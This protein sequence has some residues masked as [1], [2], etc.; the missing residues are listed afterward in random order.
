MFKKERKME[1]EKEICNV[2]KRERKKKE[3]ERKRETDRDKE[4]K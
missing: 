4:R 1:I 3:K 2:Y